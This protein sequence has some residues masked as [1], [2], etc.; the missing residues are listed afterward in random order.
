MNNLSYQVLLG[1]ASPRRQELIKAIVPTYQIVSVD[2]EESFPS[3]IPADQVARYLA[4]KKA[5]AY[6]QV[7][8]GYVLVT[9]DTTVVVDQEILNKPADP[10]AAVTMLRRLSGRKHQVITGV[11]LRS[12]SKLA[13][14]QVATD[15]YFQTLSEEDMQYYIATCKPYDKA[16]AYGIQEWLGMVGITQIVG[17]Y[18]NVVGLPVSRLRTELATF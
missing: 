6:Q 12:L 18:Y 9:A 15:V 7:D 17:D 11:A 1:S 8:A 13:S 4:E 3:T 10:E 2:V 16:G 14:F 5:K